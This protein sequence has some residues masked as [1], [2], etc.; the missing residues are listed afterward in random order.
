[1]LAPGDCITFSGHEYMLVSDPELPRV[2]VIPL[3]FRYLESHDAPE[4]YLPVTSA[5]VPLPVPKSLRELVDRLRKVW[6][7]CWVTGTCQV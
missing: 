1:M 5:L 3:E 4:I 2:R 7:P 6:Q